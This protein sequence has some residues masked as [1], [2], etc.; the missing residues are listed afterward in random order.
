MWFKNWFKRFAIWE[1]FQNIIKT[2]INANKIILIVSKKIKN[3]KKGDESVVILFYVKTFLARPF[4][5]K[6]PQK[7]FYVL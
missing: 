1:L 3:K 2:V 5:K 7:H 6:C 4:S